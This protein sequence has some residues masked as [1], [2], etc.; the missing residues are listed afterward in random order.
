MA[1][2]VHDAESAGAKPA[3]VFPEGGSAPES[4]DQG[5]QRFNFFE[6]AP[7]AYFLFDFNHHLLDVNLIGA[8][9]LS[10]RRAQVLDKR[11]PTFVHRPDREGV[12]SAYQRRLFH[13]P[14]G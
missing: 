3:P 13:R 8:E 14:T 9:L 6:L 11:F 12:P 7:L 1:D 10:L 2:D 4:A 5:G